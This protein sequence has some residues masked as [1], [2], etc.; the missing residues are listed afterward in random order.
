MSSVDIDSILSNVHLRE[1]VVYLYE[2]YY[3]DSNLIYSCPIQQ[4]TS[5]GN[6]QKIYVL[7]FK[8]SHGNNMMTLQWLVLSDL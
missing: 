5:L 6:V 4:M 8:G 7:K 3:I 1:T 2:D